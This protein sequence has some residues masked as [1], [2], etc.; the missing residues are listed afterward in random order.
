MTGRSLVDVICSDKKGLVDASR[1]HV[2]V[3]RERHVAAARTGDLPYPQRAIRTKDWLYI[4]NFEPDRWPMGTGPGCGKPDGPMPSFEI[5]R[6]KT[7][8]AFGDLDASPTKAWIAT[9]RGTPGNKKYFDFAFGRRPAEELYDLRNDPHQVT[10][11]ADSPEHAETKAVLAER[12]MSVLKQTGDPRVI[13]DGKTFERPP[14]V[15]PRKSKR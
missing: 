3:G 1:D 7:F 4:R 11:V 13:G 12:L 2:I 14:F 6:E 5:L 10:N 9:R 15:V 8:D